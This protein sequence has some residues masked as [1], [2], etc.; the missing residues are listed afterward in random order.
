[1]FTVA[2]KAFPQEFWPWYSRVSI[3]IDLGLFDEAE[4]L[5]AAPPPLSSDGERGYV[6]KLRA[7][8][9]KAR[10]LLEA[11]IEMLDAAI[12]LDAKDAEAREAGADAV[13]PARR[14][15]RPCGACRNPFAILPAQDQPHAFAYG[16]AL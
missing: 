13:R 16:T 11:A 3:S 14:L 2:N 6:F 12:E 5:L 4:A 8:F 15:A 9:C 10:W 1:M 7:R